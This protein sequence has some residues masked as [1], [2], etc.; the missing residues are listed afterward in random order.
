MNFGRVENKRGR[1]LVLAEIGAADIPRLEVY[2]KIDLV[3]YMQEGFTRDHNKLI[4]KVK[5]SAAKKLGIETLLS[6]IAE[7]L[8][9]NLVNLKIKFSITQARE[10]ALL[11]NKGV[12][13]KRKS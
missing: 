7:R 1:E 6:S 2:N 4:S 3:H 12:G 5:I 9:K 13:A 8:S 10:R 11:Y